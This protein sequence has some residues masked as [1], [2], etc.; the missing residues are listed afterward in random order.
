MNEERIKSG[1]WLGSLLC[2]HFRCFDTD[3][4]LAGSTSI[5]DPVTLIPRSSVPEQVAEDLR[6]TS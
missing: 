6:G 1:H 4:W 2:V 5:K 3:A